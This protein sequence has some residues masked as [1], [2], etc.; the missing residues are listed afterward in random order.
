MSIYFY[1]GQATCLN[2]ARTTTPPHIRDRDTPS[3]GNPEKGASPGGGHIHTSANKN[4]VAD[5]LYSR[6][7]R[8][9]GLPSQIRQDGR[10]L[11]CG[12]PMPPPVVDGP[13][14]SV[15]AAVGA[16]S[17]LNLLHFRALLDRLRNPLGSEGP[18]RILRGAFRIL[19]ES[20]RILKE[21][22]RILKESLESLRLPLESLRVPSGI[23]FNWLP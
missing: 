1:E 14:D 7:R 13:L 2:R 17:T 20:F 15:E 18:F 19:K 5:V 12:S 23:R 10:G 8:W 22:F 9:L 11:Q 4:A 21:P 16:E 6:E 3:P